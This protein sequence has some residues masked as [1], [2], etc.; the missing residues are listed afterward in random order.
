MQSGLYIAA[1]QADASQLPGYTQV[2]SAQL[3]YYKWNPITLALYK[4]I[5]NPRLSHASFTLNLPEGP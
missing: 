3:P 5:I 1:A 2:A 4:L